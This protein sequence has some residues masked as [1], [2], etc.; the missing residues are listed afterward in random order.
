MTLK[1]SQSPETLSVHVPGQPLVSFPDPHTPEGLGMR[2]PIASFPGSKR[3]RREHNYGSTSIV[4]GV[5]E[6]HYN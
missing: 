2:L 6:F 1:T 5:V 3:R 4:C